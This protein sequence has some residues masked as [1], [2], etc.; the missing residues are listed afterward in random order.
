[1]VDSKLKA[2][3]NSAYTMAPLPAY[4]QHEGNGVQAIGADVAGIAGDGIAQHNTA[5]T[6]PDSR[7]RAAGSCFINS[8][9]AFA[10]TPW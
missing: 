4:S 3:S 1:M 8:K 5:L 6:T 9:Q 10:F 7:G 2:R